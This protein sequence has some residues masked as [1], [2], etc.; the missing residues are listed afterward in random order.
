MNDAFLRG[1]EYVADN[2]GVAEGNLVSQEWL[3]QTMIA[4]DKLSEDMIQEMYDEAE[5]K[6]L[7]AKQLQGFIAEIW[8]KDTYNMDASMHGA[9]IDALA[10]RPDVNTFASADVELGQDQYTMKYYFSAEESARRQ[11]ETPWEAY[12]KLKTAY[13][14]KGKGRDPGTFEQFLKDRDIDET[15][16]KLSKFLGMQKV[17]PSDQL[18]AAQKFL[19][20]KIATLENNLSPTAETVNQIA[21]Y[22][23]VLATITDI[24]KDNKGTSQRL[25][26]ADAIRLAHAA[27]EGKLDKELL[28][29]CGLDVNAL[30]RPEDIYKEAINAG[31]NAALLAVVISIAP[32]IA[33]GIS[34]LISEGEV[35]T[36]Q[37]LDGGM[38]TIS[39]A[40]RA[41]ICGGLTSGIVLAAKTGKLSEA[42]ENIEPGAVASV[43]IAAVG[44]IDLAIKLASGK[45]TGLEMTRGVVK[46]YITTGV[47]Y[48]GGTLLV[49]L[50]PEFAPAYLIGSIIG[51]IVGGF[52]YNGVDS[53]LM[54]LCVEDGFTFFGLVKQDY[55]LP[56]EALADLGLELFDFE[57][58]EPAMFRYDS[59][60]P[61]SFEPVQFNYPKIGMT[62]LSRNLI[63]AT[64]VGYAIE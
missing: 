57:K 60:H 35:S 27:N 58:F 55:T 62:V 37:L 63:E 49:T 34:K 7:A 26:H 42:F 46:L 20:E 23:E 30:I 53:L 5:L 43:V 17:I 56:D 51:S 59:F 48:V 32:I 24:V 12:N 18:E 13:E 3:G 39:T 41:F 1:F 33:N 45:I 28:K 54:S 16:G 14:N 52:A 6:H 2:A 21:R 44:T 64:T 10:T 8:H 47:A 36:D 25:S 4:I 61:A 11:A 9:G 31:I 50:L 38:R 22:K 15:A 29:E 19:T 40:G